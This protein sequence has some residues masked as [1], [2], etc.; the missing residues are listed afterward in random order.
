VF[1]LF[2]VDASEQE[3]SR[4]RVESWLHKVAVHDDAVMGR[5]SSRTLEAVRDFRLRGAAGWITARVVAATTRH[6]QITL[7]RT[8]GSSSSSTVVVT[9]VWNH[10]DNVT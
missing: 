5:E 2:Q 8:E 1:L 4:R 7:R 10:H 6:S 3:K 9:L